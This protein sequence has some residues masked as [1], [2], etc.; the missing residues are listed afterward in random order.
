[1]SP[2]ADTFSTEVHVPLFLFWIPTEERE[3]LNFLIVFKVQ[4]KP[5]LLVTHTATDPNHQKNSQ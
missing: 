3:L 5:A 2:S 1:M 4:I